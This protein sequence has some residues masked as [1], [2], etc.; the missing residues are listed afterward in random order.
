VDEV[1][2]VVRGLKTVH[3]G[4]IAVHKDD[5]VRVLTRIVRHQ[6]LVDGVLPVLSLVDV[7]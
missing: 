2:D 6:H 1:A 7:L 4:H 3:D 5:P